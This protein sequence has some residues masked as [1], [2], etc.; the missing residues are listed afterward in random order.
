MLIKDK[1]II[2]S[3]YVYAYVRRL[4]KALDIWVGLVIIVLWANIF[5]HMIPIIDLL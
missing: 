2:I 3:D 1:G 5:C 4:L